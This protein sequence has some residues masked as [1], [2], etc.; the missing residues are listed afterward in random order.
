MQTFWTFFGQKK[1]EIYI[2]YDWYMHDICKYSTD[3][4]MHLKANTKAHS[5]TFF[6]VNPLP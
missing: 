6:V 4:F 3:M 1:Q 2:A 5:F